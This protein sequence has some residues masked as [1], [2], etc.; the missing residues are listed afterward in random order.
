[1]IK[2]ALEG[3]SDFET[4]ET[5]IRDTSLRI[6]AGILETMINSDRSDC[7][8]TII[9]PEGRTMS[10]AGRRGKT[11]VTVLGDITLKRAYYI[12]EHGRG[13]FPRDQKLGLDKDSLSDWVKRMIGHT[14][15][16]LSFEESSLMI[17]NLTS[18]HVSIKQVE[19]GAESLGEEIAE[20]EKSE[21]K[22][23]TP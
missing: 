16:V 7:Y 12:D 6:G 2:Q 11:F 3:F 8:P 15:S 1:M 13:Y 10:Y 18:L 5:L 9:H 4:L 14:A 23:G 20:N 19:R 22:N 17:E 21:I